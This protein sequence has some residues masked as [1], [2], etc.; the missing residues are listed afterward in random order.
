MGDRVTVA[1][2]GGLDSLVLLH[3]LRFSAPGLCLQVSAAH[4][5]HAM[6]PGSAVDATWLRGLTG[7]WRVPLHQGRAPEAPK[8]EAQARLLRYRFLEGLLEDGKM[9]RVLTAHQA[10][11]QVETI[12][13]RILRGTGLE[14]LR[15][16]PAVRQPGILRPFLPFTREELE[17]YANEARIRPRVD[18]TNASPRFARNRLRGQLLPLLEETHPGA[19]A[20]LLRL[21]RNSGRAIQALDVL[22]GRQL[23]ALT[24]ASSGREIVLDRGQLLDFPESVIGALVRR[25]TAVLGFGLTEAGTASAVEFI[26]TRRSGARLD[27]RGAVRLTREFDRIRIEGMGRQGRE[28]VGEATDGPP[29]EI[30]VP[31]TGRGELCLAGHRFQVRWEAISETSRGKVEWVSEEWDWG[32]FA[33]DD[34]SFPLSMRG[35]RP[36]DRIRI[37]GGRKKLKKV[38]RE[39]RVPLSERDRLPVLVDSEGLV[40]WLPGQVSGST[41]SHEAREGG[42]RLGLRGRGNE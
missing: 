35:W 33:P 19:R 12:L 8:S 32:E 41:G 27:L 20:S 1:C 26:R 4:F 17:D 3:L 31:G 30:G 13:F 22:V 24:V 37:R 29:I 14:G 34:L 9:D 39:S 23:E 7:A 15:G 5:D 11:D 42:W 2:S 10:D 6:R 40:V 25:A 38:L 21:A 18:P 36:G 28:S 16:I